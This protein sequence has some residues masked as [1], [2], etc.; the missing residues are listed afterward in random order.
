LTKLDICD[1]SR[2]QERRAKVFRVFF[3]IIPKFLLKFCLDQ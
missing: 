1:L 3:Q 2:I